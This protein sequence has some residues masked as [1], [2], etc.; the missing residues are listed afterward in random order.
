MLRRL[1][2]CTVAGVASLA[3]AP[4]AVAQPVAGT[5]TGEGFDACTAPDLPAMTSWLQS[6]YRAAAIYIGGVARACAQPNLSAAWVT[7][8]EA[9]GWRLLPIYVGAQ[10][11]CSDAQARIDPLAAAPQGTQSADDAI[12][13]AGALALGLGAPL[14]YDMEAFPTTDGACVAAVDAFL[15]AWTRELHAKG[16]TSGVYTSAGSGGVALTQAY[17]TG[18][19]EPDGLWYA[20]WDGR[21]L[22]TGDPYVVDG[23]WPGHRRVH[24]YRETHTESYGGVALDIDDDAIDGPVA[25]P[26]A[27]PTPA[28]PAPVPMTVSVQ[29]AKHSLAAV[30]RRGLRMTVRCSQR[31][32]LLAALAIDART[33]R[34]RHFPHVKGGVVIGASRR[35]LAGGKRTAV[36]VRLTASALARLHVTTPAQLALTARGGSGGAKGTAARAL[37]LTS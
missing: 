9:E 34:D 23:T 13:D 24:Q 30:R 14:Y 21:D 3:S 36:N 26:V 35:T 32:T 17:A 20:D 2:A 11:P 18:V 16:W 28:P 10:A 1:I 8:V 31:C 6:P 29:L 25:P 37:R 12:A 7:A 4:S 33:A 5:F 27:A 19:A 22:T 15:D